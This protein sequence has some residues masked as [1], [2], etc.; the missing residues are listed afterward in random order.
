VDYE[1]LISK[2]EFYSIIGKANQL[3]KSNLSNTYQRVI[4]KSYYSDKLFSE[5]AIV[6][7]GIPPGSILGPLFFLIYINDLSFTLKDIARPALFAYDVSSVPISI[8]S[9]FKTNLI[10]YLT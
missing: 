9:I 6:K 5:W 7:R 10:K 4:I 8:S 3:I 1:I 2:L